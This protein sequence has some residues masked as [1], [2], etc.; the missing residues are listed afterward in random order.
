MQLNSEM[1]VIFKLA[2]RLFG[3]SAAD[4][5]EMVALPEVRTVPNAPGSARGVTNLRGKV[6]VVWDLRQLLGLTTLRQ[7]TDALIQELT[8]REQDH[9]NWLAELERSIREQRAF[10]LT[11]DPHKC[12]FGIWYDTFK[13]ENLILS[14]LLKKFDEPHQAIGKYLFHWT[15]FVP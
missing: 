5:K 12:K 3:L 13:T 15:K 9:K 1:W 2:D 7:E 11:T 6:H 14:S 4:V 8:Q 10:T